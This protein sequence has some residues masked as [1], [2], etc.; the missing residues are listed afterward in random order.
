MSATMQVLLSTPSGLE[1]I[2]GVTRLRLEAPD[3]SR[4]VLPGHEPA[5]VAVRPGPAVLATGPEPQDERYLVTEGGIAWIQPQR[6][7]LVTRWAASAASLEVLREHV[8]ARRATRAAAEQ[9]ARAIAHRHEMAT[10]RALAQLR[11][12]VGQ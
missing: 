9:R 10:R 1:T 12:E 7:L 11:R 3:G 5:R 4:G 8:H 6:V 2:E